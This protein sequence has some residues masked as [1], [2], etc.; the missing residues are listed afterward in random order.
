MAESAV[1][2]ASLVCLVGLWCA[3]AAGSPLV[4][5]DIAP[6]TRIMKCVPMGDR[7]DA[8]IDSIEIFR[9]RESDLGLFVVTGR[10]G[11]S[12]T[13][14]VRLSFPN[15]RGTPYLQAIQATRAIAISFTFFASLGASQRAVLRTGTSDLRLAC[16]SALS[17]APHAAL[18]A[19]R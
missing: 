2:R 12:T 14:F 11:E 3:S 7:D 4:V 13:A 10:A 16:D 6:P 19:H 8:A 1:M 15:D 17:I 5:E 9:A 18:F